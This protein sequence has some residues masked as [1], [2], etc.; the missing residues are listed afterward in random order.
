LKIILNVTGEMLTASGIFLSKLEQ[1]ELQQSS[2]FLL[3]A[4]TNADNNIYPINYKESLKI[5]LG[6]SSGR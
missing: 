5:I 3:K 2:E 1:I 4:R 6:L